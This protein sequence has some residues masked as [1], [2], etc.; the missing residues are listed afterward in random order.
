MKEREFDGI[1]IGAGPN[2]LTA[3]AYL[4]KAGLRILVLEKRF[5]LGGGF[6]P[7]AAGH[8]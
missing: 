3:G 4:A 1:I 6:N 8:S 2:G 5:E 7:T